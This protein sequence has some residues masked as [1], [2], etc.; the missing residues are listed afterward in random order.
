MKQDSQIELENK[1]EAVISPYDELDIIVTCHDMA[2]AMPFN[3]GYGGSNQGASMMLANRSNNGS[4][5]CYLVDVNGDIQFPILGS[6][7]V[8]GLTRLQLQEKIKQMLMDG[9][10]ISD[11]YVM[12]RFYNFKIFFLGSDGGKAITIQNEKVTFLEAL[13]MAGDISVYTR[14][15]KIGVMRE[16]DGKMTIRYLD[17]RSSKVFN[18]PYFLLQQNDFIITRSFSSKYYRDEATFWMSWVSLATSIVSAATLVIMA[19]NK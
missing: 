8:A 12:V 10:Y 6:I 13:A 15:D 1:F 14:R 16:V 7:H 11:P 17:P 5:L 2:I 9:N 19:V 3:L 4:A 18:D